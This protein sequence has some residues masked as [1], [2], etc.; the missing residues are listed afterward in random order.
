MSLAD[1]AA[2][3]AAVTFFGQGLRFVLQLISVSLLARILAPADYGIFA[4]VISIVGIATVLGD[5]GL[6]MAS[7]QSQT[8][9]DAQ[10][11]NL[12]WTNTGLGL[13]LSAV[14]YFSAA[15]IAAFYDRPELVAVTQASSAAFFLSAMS[16]QFRAEVSSK[17]RFRWLAAA[18]VGSQAAGLILAIALAIQGAGYWALVAQQVCVAAVML[19]I[20]IAGADWIPGR[21]RR[22]SD[23]RA[24]Y[25]FGAN[26][27]G[28]QLY[29]Y[30]TSNADNVLVGRFVG[31]AALG[32]Y[33]R[34]YQIFRLPMQQIA[35]PMT[36]VALPVLARLQDDDRY[37]DY[38]QRAQIIL[39]YTFGGMFFVMAATADPTIDLLLGD[40]W[41]EAKPIFAVLAIGGVFQALGYVYYWIFLSKARTGL[42]LRYTLIGRT[43]MLGAMAIGVH[44]GPIGVAVGSTIGQILMWGL[45]GFIAVPKTGVNARALMQ[46][47][48]RPLVLYTGMLLIAAPLTVVLREQ[49][50]L[51]TLGA[52]CLSIG[53]YLALATW[54]IRGVRNDLEL[55]FDAVRRARSR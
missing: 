16:A 33:T 36:R 18:D 32:V 2:R 48:V 30:V 27:L 44:W 39:S 31:T 53:C 43:V 38:A 34:A 41:G 52:L 12:F 50:A 55:V 14:V 24:L 5:F 13:A 28:V 21:P 29:T 42:Q 3:G 8:L 37:D 20:L 51:T 9:T 49:P 26:T 15:P 17:L 25:R 4:M 40:Q 19:C 11:S 23:M 45:N 54:L 46:I 47:T 22:N 35:A 7:I 1:N 10:R 6:S